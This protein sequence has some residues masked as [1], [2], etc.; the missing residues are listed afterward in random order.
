MADVDNGIQDTL[1]ATAEPDEEAKHRCSKRIL[2]VVVL[3]L[4]VALGRWL[5][6]IPAVAAAPPPS[7]ASTLA[8]ADGRRR[9]KLTRLTVAA[10]LCL[11]ACPR[12]V[13]AY[14]PSAARSS[15]GAARRPRTPCS[16]G[17]AGRRGMA[18]GLWMAWWPRWPR[19]QLG[20]QI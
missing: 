5:G 11:L 2:G 17:R 20:G 8:T 1:V 4:G 14:A 9:A 10:G 18:P 3:L 7:T 13:G 12:A 15:A 16:Y 6:R 19:G